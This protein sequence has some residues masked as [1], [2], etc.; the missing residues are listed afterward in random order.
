MAKT[1]AER[2]KEYRRRKRDAGN[3]SAS[4]PARHERDENVTI[5][6]RD[7]PDVSSRKKLTFE[8]LP[9]HIQEQIDKYAGNSM[10]TNRDEM[11]RR[12]LKYQEQTCKQSTVLLQV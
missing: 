1:Q 9:K 4:E 8:D 11:I 2:S 10:C 12:A 6:E 3:V 7:A 5:Q